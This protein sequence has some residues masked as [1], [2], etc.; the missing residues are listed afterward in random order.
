[1]RGHAV[2]I[3]GIPAD[4]QTLLQGVV[5]GRART[6]LSACTRCRNAQQ[7]REESDSGAGDDVWKHGTGLAH[8]WVVDSRPLALSR[9]MV[10]DGAQRQLSWAVREI[11]HQD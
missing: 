4:L 6:W 11:P 9:R 10:L 8:L 3:P 7:I 1:M 2:D 5:L